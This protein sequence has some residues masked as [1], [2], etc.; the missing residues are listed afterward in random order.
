[1]RKDRDYIDFLSIKL[2]PAHPPCGSGDR[3]RPS[4]PVLLPLSPQPRYC[5]SASI[6][7]TPAAV[8]SR[9]L[10]TSTTEIN[11]ASL[12]IVFTRVA[13]V[14]HTIGPL[15]VPQS[16]VTSPPSPWKVDQT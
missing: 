2:A 3:G 1:M 11:P 12:A 9:R 14:H 16:G 6:I 5:L 15:A 7:T 4:L 8:P 10:L 13:H